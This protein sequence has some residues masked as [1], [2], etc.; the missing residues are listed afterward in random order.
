[1]SLLPDPLRTRL[2]FQ[3]RRL[4]R[5]VQDLGRAR[6]FAD[7]RSRNN[8]AFPVKGHRLPI[9]RNLSGVDRSLFD[10]KKV[11]LR[12][13]IEQLDGVLIPGGKLFSLW[14]LMGPPTAQRG[15]REG[16][17]LER[18]R[19]SSGIGGGLCQLA[20][21]LFWLALHSELN[22]VERHH[23]SVDL[24]PDDHR[25]VP[26]GTGATIVYNFKDL[27][28]FNPGKTTYQFRLEVTDDALVARLFAAEPPVHRYV[29]VESDHDFVNASDGLYRRNTIRREKWDTLGNRV[30]TETLFRNFSK[31]RYSAQE[32][33][34]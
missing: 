12:L 21:A 22:V 31:C 8:L 4:I 20:N 5:R 32:A 24:F 34:S 29:V 25:T 16:L 1:M 19:P 23:H 11:N 14:R 26:F 10:N 18:G 2:S 17:V 27:R 3:A 13:A 7:E 6:R 28:L 15:F 9:Y 33:F 30:A